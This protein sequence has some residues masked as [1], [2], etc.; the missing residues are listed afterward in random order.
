MCCV[1]RG[2]PTRRETASHSFYRG[3]N[4]SEIIGC[5]IAVNQRT[6]PPQTPKPA[7]PWLAATVGARHHGEIPAPAAGTAVIWRNA[8]ANKVLCNRHLLY[9]A[10]GFVTVKH[11]NNSRSHFDVGLS[12]KLEH[13]YDAASD[14]FFVL[15]QPRFA[16]DTAVFA[17][18]ECTVSSAP[19]V[20]IDA[21]IGSN[22]AD[23]QFAAPRCIGAR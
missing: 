10:T 1:N 5:A 9:A 3:D 12:R 15:A 17:G 18:V 4:Q 6:N 20:P 16:W 11:L 8:S 14:A 7:I 13:P 22:A 2:L 23:A 19:F 21:T